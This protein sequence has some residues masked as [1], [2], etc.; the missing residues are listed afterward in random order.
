MRLFCL[1]LLL[2]S[3]LFSEVGYIEP[4]GKDRGIMFCQNSN[5]STKKKTDPLTYIALKIIRFRQK[6]LSPVDGPRS[7]FRPT[8]SQYM[9]EAIQ[10]HGCIK[11]YIMGCDRLL[12]ENKEKW[13]YPTIAK[14]ENLYK[15]DPVPPLNHETD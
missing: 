8:S 10:K 6:V 2:I 11:G 15:W 14:N 4:W 1:F 3:S 5:N 7:H 13:V 9:F 12:R